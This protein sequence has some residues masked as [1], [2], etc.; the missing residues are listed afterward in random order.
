MRS[1]SGSTEIPF[2]GYYF[3]I[4][5]D[6]SPAA[7]DSAVGERLVMGHPKPTATALGTHEAKLAARF[8]HPL[9]RASRAFRCISAKETGFFASPGFV[10]L[11]T[12]DGSGAGLPPR[13]A[14]C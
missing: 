6:A 8:L 9:R 7:T 5:E 10:A 12:V 2:K 1:F 11:G 14:A 4:A 3:L 13:A